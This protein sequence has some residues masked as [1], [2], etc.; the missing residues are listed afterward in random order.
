MKKER[1][2]KKYALER[3]IKRWIKISKETSLAEVVRFRLQYDCGE[4][5]GGDTCNL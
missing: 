4:S 2:V 1:S 5:G 3:L